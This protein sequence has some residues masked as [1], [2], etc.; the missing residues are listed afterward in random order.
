MGWDHQRERSLVSTFPAE[1]AF[2]LRWQTAI[3]FYWWPKMIGYLKMGWFNIFS[4]GLMMFNGWI[5]HK[6]T[7]TTW[8]F[9]FLRPQ[10]PWLG[11]DTVA[12]GED[13]TG[14]VPARPQ[15]QG[16]HKTR[17]HFRGDHSITPFR[18][19]HVWC[20]L[21]PANAKLKCLSLHPWWTGIFVF[22]AGRNAHSGLLEH[23]WAHRS[24]WVCGCYS[25][26]MVVDGCG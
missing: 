1:S 17:W 14:S 24:G 6:R 4:Y 22:C 25:K 11:R 2:L 16:G 7:S 12:V 26:W 13:G 18:M 3:P 10:D 9:P 8:P 15:P 23:S 21:E 5:I 19:R 20:W